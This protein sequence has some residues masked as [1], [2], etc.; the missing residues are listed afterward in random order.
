[1]QCLRCDGL[2][3][4]E[5]FYDFEDDTGQNCFDGLRCLVCGE[6]VDTTILINRM[7]VGCSLIHSECDL[8]TPK[9]A[10]WI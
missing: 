9:V 5:R 2:M 7:A 6:I 10:G 3:I 1:M 4:A 8:K